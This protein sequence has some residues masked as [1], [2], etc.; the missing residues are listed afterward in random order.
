MLAA[1]QLT[2]ELDICPK[3]MISSSACLQH[4]LHPGRKHPHLHR[5]RDG[6]A[7]QHLLGVR[8]R[9]CLRHRQLLHYCRR[10]RCLHHHW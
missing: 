6:L 7:G 8:H 2:L 5:L 3:R 4:G 9:H 1:S 10:L